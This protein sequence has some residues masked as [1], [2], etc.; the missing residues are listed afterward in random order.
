MVEM[1]INS[2]RANLTN[3][4]RV[5]VLQDRF[6]NT[7]LPIWIGPV[8]ADAI[9]MKLH[10]VEMERPSTHDLLHSV[11]IALGAELGYVLVNDLQQ[12]TFYAKLVLI[13]HGQER[14]VDSRPSD[15]LALAVRADAPIYA[16][17]AVLAKAG[18][19]LEEDTGKPEH[20]IDEQEREKL[21]AF[22][23]F[24]RELNLEDFERKN[25]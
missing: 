18:L 6:S 13:V 10:N 22:E 14:E 25:S 21:S 12:D 9:A 4:Q 17:E 24:I 7:I 11:I 2:I 8:E 15:A 1:I 16:E 20:H 19:T 5:I 23:D 3:C